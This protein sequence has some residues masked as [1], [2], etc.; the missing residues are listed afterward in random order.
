MEWNTESMTNDTISTTEALDARGAAA[1]YRDLGNT[2]RRLRH[3]RRLT[4]AQVQAQSGGRILGVSLRSYE[5][6]TRKP[7]LHTLYALA[8][9]YE[10]PLWT[11]LPDEDGAPPR[12]LV[13]VEDL[14]RWLSDGFDPAVLA[15]TGQEGKA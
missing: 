10:V 15:E 14:I 9:F 5:T 7:S 12:T 3:V 8:K 2:L 13:A 6:A 11:I 4:L 1:L